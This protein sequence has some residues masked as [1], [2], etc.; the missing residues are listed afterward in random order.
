MSEAE[1]NDLTARTAFSGKGPFKRGKIQKSLQEETLA[2]TFLSV[3]GVKPK[4]FLT[5]NSNLVREHIARKGAELQAYVK[6]NDVPLLVKDLET[7]LNVVRKE[8]AENVTV[9]GDAARAATDLVD[10]YLRIVQKGPTWKNKNG[11]TVVRASELLR[12]RKDID[13][14]FSAAKRPPSADVATGQAQ[15][16]NSLRR[17]MNKTLNDNMS[18]DFVTRSLKTQSNLYKIQ[19]ALL[20]KA[21]KEFNNYF[22]RAWKYSMKFLPFRGEVNQLAA[23]GFGVGGLGAGAIVG[24]LMAKGLFA[25]AAAFGSYAAIT[26]PA[27]RRILAKMIEGQTA[28]LR[29][30]GKGTQAAI[31]LRA[32]RAYLIALM[33][34]QNDLPMPPMSEE[35]LIGLEHEDDQDKINATV[36]E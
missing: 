29:T 15:A 24:P 26:A 35:S 19:D 32:Q 5:E 4:N 8:L 33:K 16:L 20:P 18:D 7:R 21:A 3:P 10:D 17:E 6:K 9:R 23:L 25:G 1:I 13:G 14:Q 27:T 11:D 28:I 30:V 22:S 12:A 31:D 36:G 34:G 2:D